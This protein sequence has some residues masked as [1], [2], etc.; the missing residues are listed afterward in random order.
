MFG[1]LGSD[2]IPRRRVH[3]CD[4]TQPYKLPHQQHSPLQTK[5]PSGRTASP[6]C[7]PRCGKLLPAWHTNRP[8]LLLLLQLSQ[9]PLEQLQSVSSSKRGGGGGRGGG[10]CWLTL[11]TPTGSHRPTAPAAVLGWWLVFV[12]LLVWHTAV[13]AAHAFQPP[14]LLLLPLL[15]P[16]PCLLPPFLAPSLLLLL[17]PFCASQAWKSETP[18]QM[19]DQAD[20]QTCYH[21][22]QL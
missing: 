3:T 21:L 13:A 18:A 9:F 14:L 19:S 5:G 4:P 22:D 6:L 1:G 10:T 2:S 7:G 12:R 17:P 8:P 16:F 20:D 11:P 15:S